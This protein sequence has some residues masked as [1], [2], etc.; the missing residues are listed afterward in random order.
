MDAMKRQIGHIS[1]NEVLIECS[2]RYALGRRTYIVGNIVKEV[3]SNLPNMSRRAKSVIYR[4][5]SKC[6]DLGDRTDRDNWIMLA[7]R[8]ATELEREVKK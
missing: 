1:G 8:I 7:N 4:D 3:L 2:V 6:E 5:I